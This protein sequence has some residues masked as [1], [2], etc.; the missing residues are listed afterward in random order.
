MNAD[1]KIVKAKTWLILN[2]PFFGALVLRLKFKECNTL[3]SPTAA[4]DG[5]SLLW[6]RNF[7]DSL[8]IDE[9]RGLLAHEVMHCASQHHT[10]RGARDPE[11]WNEAGDHVINLILKQEGLQLP[12]GG[13][14]DEQYKGMSTEHVYQML[15][16][17]DP[18]TTPQSSEFG[19]VVDAGS[20]GEGQGST[21]QPGSAQGHTL[22]PSELAEIE[23]DWKV[24]VQQA[25]NA[26]KAAGKLPAHL[27]QFVDEV[28]Q[29]KIP[30]KDMLRNFCNQPM[31]GD[32]SWMRGNRRHL[33]QG[34][35]LPSNFTEGLGTVVIAVDTSASVSMEEL[36][37]FQSEL[38]CILEDTTPEKIHV[39]YVDT[40]IAGT[41]EYSADDLPVRLEAKGRGGTRFEPAFEWV[42]AHEINPAVFIY[43]TDLEA[44]FNMPEPH[45]PVMWVTTGNQKQDEVPF[46]TLTNLEV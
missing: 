27:S 3:P 42:E 15:P 24:A 22:S 16:N 5:V 29:P 44:S 7:I 12:E 33:H 39:L 4:T 25:A 43:L 36:A 37:Q 13:L 2:K 20:L 18:E 45:Y 30:W 14:W 8:T 32:Y 1:Q 35:Y 17:P 6:D 31:K 40:Q 23:Q 10:R 26:A 19:V 41:E 38:N 34:L 46:G 9:I 11:K 28:V 21:G